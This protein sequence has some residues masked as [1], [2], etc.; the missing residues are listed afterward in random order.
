MGTEG[1][2]PSSSVKVLEEGGGRVCEVASGHTV[3]WLIGVGTAPGFMKWVAGLLWNQA[4]H[5]A[6]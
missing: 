6:V 3:A 4:N 1:V 5:R 2:L